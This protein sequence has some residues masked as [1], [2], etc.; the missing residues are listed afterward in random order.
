MACGT[1]TIVFKNTALE[2]LTCSPTIGTS[3]EYRDGQALGRAIE[4]LLNDPEDLTR[5]SDAGINFVRKNYT[6]E[7]YVDKHIHFYNSLIEIQ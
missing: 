3:V 5:R 1:P 7:K 2:N 6:I 4:Q